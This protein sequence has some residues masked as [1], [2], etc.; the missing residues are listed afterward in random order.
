[1]ND[2][3]FFKELTAL[4]KTWEVKVL[5]LILKTLG[6]HSSKQASN[7]V[8]YG[9]L[10]GKRDYGISVGFNTF[11]NQTKY[12]LGVLKVLKDF[13]AEGEVTC[14]DTTDI[15]QVSNYRSFH[16]TLSVNT[17][18]RNFVRKILLNFLRETPNV[19]HNILIRQ[20]GEYEVDGL[21]Y[22]SNCVNVSIHAVPIHP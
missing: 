20:V 1:M 5:P 3:E 22:S 9:S 6:I 7:T 10:I 18:I 19:E 16:V 13:E 8:K 21:L 2:E 11:E 15:V 17:D 14:T 12:I 4:N